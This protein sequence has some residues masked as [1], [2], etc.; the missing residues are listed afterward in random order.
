MYTKLKQPLESKEVSEEK[1]SQSSKEVSEEELSEEE[2]EWEEEL[3]DRRNNY[4]PVEMSA[5]KDYRSRIEPDNPAWLNIGTGILYRKY[6]HGKNNMPPSE[7]HLAIQVMRGIYN[8][9]QHK[10]M[11]R[12]LPVSER[13][14]PLHWKNVPLRMELNVDSM[15]DLSVPERNAI[16]HALEHQN[17]RSQE[18]I[19]HQKR[20]IENELPKVAEKRKRMREEV[21]D[22]GSEFEFNYDRVP[23]HKKDYLLDEFREQY[24]Q[25]EE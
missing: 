8:V 13:P 4:S 20:R 9:N 16:W 25:E 6:T 11:W 10:N 23:S 22:N 3:K 17:P 19:A 18:K 24:T 7:P 2:K 12:H 14:L 5:V 21:E 15:Y 1:S